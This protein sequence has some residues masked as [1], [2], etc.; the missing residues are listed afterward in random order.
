[1]AER[2][3]LKDHKGTVRGPYS[4]ATLRQLAEAKKLNLSWQISNDKVHWSTAA[5]VKNL[6]SGLESALQANLSG[7]K[8]YRNLTRQEVL[9]LFL[10]KF[11]LN[12]DN[13]KDTFPFLQNLRVWWA[14]LT[15]PTGGFVIT[16]VTAAGV[17]HVNYDL[18][19]GES[20]DIDEAEAEKK[21]ARGV[22]Q[23][24]W[25]RVVL[26][27]LGLGWASWMLYD[28]AMSFSPTFGTIK[29]IVFT[30]AAVGGFIY[31]TKHSKVF[32]GYTLDPAAV[33]R[34][35]EIKAALSALRSCSRVWM[36][37]V[38]AH[39]GRT[40]WKYHAGDAFKVARLPMAFFTRSIPNVETNIRVNGITYHSKA[41][42]F[43]PEK[44]LLIDGSDVRNVP[45]QVLTVGVDSLEYVE[46]EGN[47][48]R[49]TQV[50]DRRW[51]FINRDGSRD[52]RF[53]ANVQLPVV[54]CGLLT[55]TV[56]STQ[57]DMM[58]TN[59]EAPAAFAT[60]FDLLR[61]VLSPNAPRRKK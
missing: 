37:R 9:S 52:R 8:R 19:T 53:N 40:D 56:G 49:D 48:Y 61:K 11:V 15:L 50:I 47:M 33:R 35:E 36:Y 6:F 43:L 27:L 5:K 31:K 22:Q 42:Y 46:A 30:A 14:K 4:G 54:R 28:F 20:Q 12:N 7:E 26:I 55:L 45:Y 59:P 16:E 18:A 29:T 44:I 39:A 41:V 57:L 60:Q 24:N 2:Y 51:K 32:V 38:Q 1:M 3:W 10:D 58:T 25:F 23:F 17:R 21:V 13:F 34:L